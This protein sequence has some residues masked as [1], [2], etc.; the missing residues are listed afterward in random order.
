MFFKKKKPKLDAKVRFQ[1]KQFT[2]KLGSARSYRRTAVAVPESKLQRWL[3]NIGLGS[4]WSQILVGL[5]VLVIIYLIYLPNFLTIK[6]IKISGLSESQ[7]HDLDSR[8]RDQITEVGFYRAQNNLFL[9]NDDL[10]KTAAAKLASVNSILQVKKDYKNQ[11][12]IIVAE[13]KYEKYLVATQEKVFDVYNDGTFKAEAGVARD[14]WINIDNPNMIKVELY[15][16]ANSQNGQ[17]FFDPTLQQFISTLN[18]RLKIME[19]FKI[20]YYSFHDPKVDRVVTHDDIAEQVQSAEK[21]A[22]ASAAISTSEDIE[23]ASTSEAQT[24]PTAQENPELKLPF[25]SSEVNVV[26]YKGADKK[27]FFKVIFDATRDSQ[28]TMEDLK[29]L[30]AQ[31]APDRFNQLDYIDMRID[32]KAFICLLNAPCAK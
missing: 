18:D 28:K 11:T 7:T 10:A 6:E 27:R 26:F 15:E 31:T 12:L 5:F 30:L 17:Q 4:K 3:A 22:T 9:F 29:L 14:N 1:H 16:N 19:N 25:N 24:T 8:I 21:P 20:A 13:S 32:S 2:T 23:P